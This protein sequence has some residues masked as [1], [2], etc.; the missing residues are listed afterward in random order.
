[1][2]TPPIGPL[3]G[4]VLFTQSGVFELGTNNIVATNTARVRI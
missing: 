1:M 3:C 2:P 4:T